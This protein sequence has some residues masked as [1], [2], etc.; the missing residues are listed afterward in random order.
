MDVEIDNLEIKAGTTEE[1]ERSRLENT[2]YDDAV[3]QQKIEECVE[4][5]LRQMMNR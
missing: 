4:R 5:M 2:D 3:L 1:K